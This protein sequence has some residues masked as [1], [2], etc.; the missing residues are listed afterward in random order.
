[1]T[2]QA[3]RKYAV[4]LIG[5]ILLAIGLGVVIL[6]LNFLENE[7]T[8]KTQKPVPRLPMRL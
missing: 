6:M 1:M 2:K 3:S 7:E 5:A 8:E 4:A